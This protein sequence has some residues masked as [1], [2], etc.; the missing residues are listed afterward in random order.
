MTNV[1][2]AIAPSGYTRLPDISTTANKSKRKKRPMN[3]VARRKIDPLNPLSEQRR[4]II[5]DCVFE[6][7]LEQ[8]DQ[9]S[10]INGTL[11][12]FDNLANQ[13]T[14]SMKYARM[15]ITDG[16]KLDNEGLKV[17]LS[18]T[19]SELNRLS[20]YV[21]DLDALLSKI[22]KSKQIETQGEEEA[23]SNPQPAQAQSQA[24]NAAPRGM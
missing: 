1:T 24:T 17:S 11:Q 19:K 16:L 23:Q 3:K 9:Q 20:S 6:M 22:Y 18:R 2:G 5:R 4:A 13:V 10:A 7:I 15:Y 12:I 21:S 14:M 8:E